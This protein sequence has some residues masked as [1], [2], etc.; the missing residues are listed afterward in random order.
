[1][2]CG[3]FSWL[4]ISEIQLVHIFV[5]LVNIHHHSRMTPC[6]CILIIFLCFFLFHYF[7]FNNSIISDTH[8]K[9]IYNRFF[10]FR[11]L[12]LNLNRLCILLFILIGIR[13]M[14]CLN[15]RNLSNRFNNFNIYF[16]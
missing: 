15:N 11:E 16:H 13:I 5:I 4:Y 3:K 7:C 9:F 14:K 10:K 12:V 6:N 1:M 8:R 2:N